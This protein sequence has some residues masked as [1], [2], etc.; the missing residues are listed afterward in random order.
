MAPSGQSLAGTLEMRQSHSAQSAV[1]VVIV[2]PSALACP[3]D[4]FNKRVK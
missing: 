1:C 2:E 4:P 3:F